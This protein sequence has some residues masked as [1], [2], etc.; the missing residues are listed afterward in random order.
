MNPF[1][2]NLTWLY[3]TKKSKPVRDVKK[4]VY[5]NGRDLTIVFLLLL[6]I[7][8]CAFIQ[9]EGALARYRYTNK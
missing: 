3:L 2:K 7:N 4:Y 5:E 6:K 8:W 1:F 9:S